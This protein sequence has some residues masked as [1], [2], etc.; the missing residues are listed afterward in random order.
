MIWQAMKIESINS[1]PTKNYEDRTD[2]AN[3]ELG[4]NHSSHRKA[5]IIKHPTDSIWALFSNSPF[6]VFD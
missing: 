1:L 3:S 4:Y 5:K 2:I 6:M